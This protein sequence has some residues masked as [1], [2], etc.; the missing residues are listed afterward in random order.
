MFNP[1]IWLWDFRYEGLPD[2]PDEVEQPQDGTETSAH[3]SMSLYGFGVEALDGSVGHVEQTIQENG[4]ARVVV[5]TGPWIF[6][7]KVVLP[8]GVVDRVDR[9]A[10]KVYVRRTK[11]EIKAA[12]RFD[13][14]AQD[15]YLHQLGSY[16][17]E[18]GSG[19]RPS[20]DDRLKSWP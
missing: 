11:D 5:D 8:A 1:Q 17:D 19:Y 14:G 16:Y 18:G 7:T 6:G 4:F 13:E 3:E 12:P 10:E 2:Q 20:A 15:E 9:A